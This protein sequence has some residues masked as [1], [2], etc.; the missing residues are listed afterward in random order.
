MTSPSLDGELEQWCIA[1][2]KTPDGELQAALDWACG[3]GGADCSMIQ[4]NQTC[5]LP[6]TVRDH[7]SF[8]F[9]NYFQ[10]FKHKGGSCYFKGAAIITELDPKMDG[11]SDAQMKHMLQKSKLAQA[12]IK[13]KPPNGA[14]VAYFLSSSKATA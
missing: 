14:K 13:A 7:A 11:T 8:A 10:K 12:A 6:N 4:E 5:Y 3:G 9:N 2:E 1:D